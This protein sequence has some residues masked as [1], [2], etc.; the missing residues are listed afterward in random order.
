[1]DYHI[2]LD[3]CFYSV[4][5]KYLKEK[6]EVKYTHTVVEIYHKGKLIA[7]HPKQHRANERSTHKEHMPPNHQYQHEKMNPERLIKWAA[8][9][10]EDAKSFVTHRIQ[11][12]EYPANAYRG[13]IAILLLEKIYGKMTLNQAL[14]YAHSINAISTRSI[15]SILEKKL[16][17]QAVNNTTATKPSKHKNLR[18][19]NYYQ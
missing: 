15:R 8:S 7:T 9:I 4:P 10:G 2:E 5:F 19:S 12:A 18:G 13:V 16:Y 11:T 3:R 6:V 14:G 1:M 17:L